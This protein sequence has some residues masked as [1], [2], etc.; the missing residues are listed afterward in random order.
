[1][2]LKA[3]N[4]FGPAPSPCCAQQG[5]QEGRK[6][7]LASGGKK[8][9]DKKLFALLFPF[10]HDLIFWFGHREDYKAVTSNLL[11]S[12]PSPSLLFSSL[13]ASPNPLCLLSHR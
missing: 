9:R 2:C 10:L 6:L 1:M 8:R 4:L 5:Q 13:S 11:L 7:L 3:H 12:A